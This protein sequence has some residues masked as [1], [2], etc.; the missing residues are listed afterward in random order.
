MKK[1]YS[2]Q[3]SV[4]VRRIGHYMK[5]KNLKLKV[6]LFTKLNLKNDLDL[7]VKVKL[8]H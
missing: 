1:G 3:Q 5:E 2:F 7:N 4:N 6:T 8:K